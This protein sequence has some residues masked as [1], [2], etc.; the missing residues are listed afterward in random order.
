MFPDSNVSFSKHVGPLF[1]QKCTG[2]PCHGGSAP[3]P[4]NNG[5]NLEYPSYTALMNH[6]PTL[7]V[8]RDTN[9]LLLERL[10]GRLPPMPPPKFLSL[11]KNQIIGIKKWIEEGAKYN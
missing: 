9:S 3:A 6:T 11:T 10:D 5:L 8:P 4:A 7:V 2:S 1:Q